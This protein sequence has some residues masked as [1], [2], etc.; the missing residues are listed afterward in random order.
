MPEFEGKLGTLPRDTAFM[1]RADRS[2]P[3]QQFIDVA[4]LLKRLKFT[5]MAVQTQRA[6]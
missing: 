3:L 6:R 2:I 5:K 4:D 1:V